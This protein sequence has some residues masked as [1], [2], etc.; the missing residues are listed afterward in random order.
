MSDHKNEQRETDG[1]ELEPETV[2]DL[3]A[4]EQDADQVR[5]GP[6]LCDT[7]PTKPT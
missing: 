7:W 1:L 5:G 6:C 3:D 4:E 2:A